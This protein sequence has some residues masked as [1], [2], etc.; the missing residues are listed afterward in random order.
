[1]I[2]DIIKS[3]KE[4]LSKISGKPKSYDDLISNRCI[5]LDLKM[6]NRLGYSDTGVEAYHLTNSVFL[7]GLKKIEKTD[8]QLSTFTVG[9]PELARLPSQPNCLIR[10]IGTEVIRGKSDI[11]T[12]VDENGMRWINHNV[13]ERTTKFMLTFAIDGLLSRLFREFGVDF[14]ADRQPSSEVLKAIKK[15]KDKTKF[16]KAYFK[17]IENWIDNGGYKELQKYLNNAAE[18]KYN[19][20]I[21]TKFKIES[22]AVLDSENGKVENFCKKHNIKYDGVFP[23]RALGELRI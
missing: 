21:L 23:S 7:N 5:P 6:M 3:I 16:H 13:E 15:V 1:M 17:A 9:G 2:R 8:K 20:V 12:T 14:D 22:I 4:E 11:W 19:E 10:L 18:M